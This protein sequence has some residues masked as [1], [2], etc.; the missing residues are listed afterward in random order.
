MFPRPWA[1][2][3]GPAAVAWSMCVKPLTARTSPAIRVAASWISDARRRTEHPAA[4]QRNAALSAG[5]STAPASRSS[6]SI[7]TAVSASASAAAVSRP[8]SASQSE[9]ASSRSACS[10]GDRTPCSGAAAHALRTPSIASN[11]ASVRPAAPSA[12]AACSTSASR[13]PR[14]AALRSIADAGLFSSWAS[15]AESRP[16]EI[17]FSSCSSFD[18]NSRARSTIRWTRIDVSS[19]HSRAR[20]LMCSLG[21]TRISDGSWTS[22]LPGA[23]TRREYGS[24]PL[25]SPAR[26]S[27]SFCGPEP[28]SMKIA[29]RPERMTNIPS[30]GAPFVEI[31]SPGSSRRTVPRAASHSSS[32][33]GAAPR[34]L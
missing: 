15:P 34:I 12:R 28:R 13:L 9:M 24:I 5:P 16:S 26:H 7:F 31:V 19:W 25:T 32:S 27:V 29:M 22:T 4:A 30:T 17:I 11:W 14:S 21:T 8:R 2:S 6:A 20:A 23:E 33:R 1:R 3:T 10:I 18:V